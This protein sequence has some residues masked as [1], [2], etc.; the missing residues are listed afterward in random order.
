MS[1]WAADELELLERLAGNIPVPMLEQTFHAWAGRHGRPKR[2][3]SAILY[4]GYARGLSFE[5]VGDW[6]TIEY[7]CK[8][9]GCSP[10]VPEHWIW[11]E[12]LRVWRPKVVSGRRST[13]RKPYFRREW[14]REM[15]R[16][17]PEL[18]AEY[19]NEQLLTLL[20]DGELVK[21]MI[22]L[23]LRRPRAV[24]PIP[25]RCVESGEVYRSMRAASRSM[26]VQHRDIRYAVDRGVR[27]CGYHWEVAA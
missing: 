26:R 2:S 1:Q 8:V 3:R 5:L 15:V 16:E 6:I 24:A 11:S 18:L 19:G 25:V 13:R 23:R 27:V 9:L 4:Q 17:R 22:G 20:E 14:V 7:V 12:W 10:G 21:W